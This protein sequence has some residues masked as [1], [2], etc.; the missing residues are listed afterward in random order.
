MKESALKVAADISSFNPDPETSLYGERVARLGEE[1]SAAALA[2]ILDPDNKE[3]YKNNIVTLLSYWN[4][5]KENNLYDE[6]YKTPGDHWTNAIP[7]GTAFTRSVIALDIVWNDLT[8]KERG[9]I[10]TGMQ[11]V[12]DNYIIFENHRIGGLGVRGIWAAFCQNWYLTEDMYNQFM[13]YFDGYI[14]EDGVVTIGT[15]YTEARFMSDARLCKT[16]LPIVLEHMGCIDDYYSNPRYQKFEEFILGYANAPNGNHWP[17]GD[18]DVSIVANTEKISIDAAWRAGMYNEPAALSAAYFMKGRSSSMLESY[19][20]MKNDWPDEAKPPQSKIFNDGGA[21][22]YED[23]DNAGSLAAVLYNAKTHGDE[24]AHKEVN[25]MSLAAYG[26]V[27]T[28]NA[29]Y[30]AWGAGDAGYTWQYINNRAISANTVLIDYTIGDI[31]SPNTENDHQ[32]KDGAGI[33]NGFTTEVFDYAKGDSGDALPN[34]SFYRSLMM[35]TGQDG[36]PGYFVSREDITTEDAGSTATVVHRPR[37]DK[38]EVLSENTEYTWRMNESEHDVDFSVFLVNPPSSTE[39][40]DGLASNTADSINLK[41]LLAKYE[42]DK[43]KKALSAA[44]YFPSD[45]LHEKAKLERIKA[46]AFYGTSIDFGNSVNDYVFS[47]SCGTRASYFI[48]AEEGKSSYDKI[49]FDADTA[50]VRK[51]K[52]SLGFFFIENGT[53][54]IANEQ[55]MQSSEPVNAFIKDG[56]GKLEASANT[57]LTFISYGISGIKLNGE[58]ADFVKNQGNIVVTVPAGSYDVEL[59]Y[60]A[61]EQLKESIES[62]VAKSEGLKAAEH[63]FTI[64]KTELPEYLYNEDCHIISGWT[65]SAE[66]FTECPEPNMR[67]AEDDMNSFEPIDFKADYQSY[68]DGYKIY[69]AYFTVSSKAE[70]EY[71]IVFPY[72][73]AERF[74]VF[75]NEA[76]CIDIVKPALD[77]EVKVK[78]KANAALK[79]EIRV[80]CEAVKG[81][82]SGIKGT[83]VVTENEYRQ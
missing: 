46:G 64:E 39:I 41:V 66:K 71:I 22:F 58:D 20:L 69:R 48:P 67:I 11:A 1:V 17:F 63:K 32:S 2:Y 37:S 10:Q 16:F 57:K 47:G 54:L 83:V 8:T 73:I 33:M 18:T 77:K 45:S 55:G 29:G 9:Y 6:I 60:D 82:R 24:H 13:E 68:L 59:L 78:V 74:I 51:N 53:Y 62:I 81:K 14:S 30:R 76:E 28:V 38:Y 80:V 15:G 35:I 12:S 4:P 52:G 42:S 3:Y 49:E 26:E 34:G 23:Y 43:N 72:V 56:K 70:Q 7:P 40:I 79:N 5:D 36:V 75:V 27:L 21:W 19:V 50:I 25:A 31:K 44:V 65:I 61:E